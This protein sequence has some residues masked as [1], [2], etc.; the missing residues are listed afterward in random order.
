MGA[1]V[2][3]AEDNDDY[4]AVIRMLL[5]H[6]GCN[7]VEASNGREAMEKAQSTHP[8]LII[9][10]WIMPHLGG[11]EATKR[12]KEDPKTRDIPIVIC[13]ALSM[14]ALGHT[15]L[16]DCA[17]EVIQKPVRLE[18]IR[19]IV[20]K[21]MPERN[22]QQQTSATAEKKKAPDLVEAWRLLRKIKQAI[23]ENSLDVG[24]RKTHDFDNRVEDSASRLLLKTH[25]RKL[26]A[27][28]VQLLHGGIGCLELLSM[29]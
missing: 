11:L 4:R 8:D 12:L 3:V 1:T 26:F 25:G 14:E 19:D 20:H 9:M 17:H 2:L 24:L 16:L 6:L 7:V 5:T 22:Q 28:L 18:K 27:G 23:N 21:Y 10:D 13:T 29:A 15:K